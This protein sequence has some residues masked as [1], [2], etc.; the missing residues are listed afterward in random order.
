L[1]IL[2]EISGGRPNKEI[3]KDLG[4]STRT[5]EGHLHNIFEK[6]RVS[7]RT[8]AVVYAAHHG[9]ISMEGPGSA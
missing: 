6:L 9:I 5:V 2:R 1:A 3:A 4:I 7:S 8:E